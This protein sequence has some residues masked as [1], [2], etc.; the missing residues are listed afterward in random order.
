MVRGC[1]WPWNFRYRTTRA[2]QKRKFYG[3]WEPSLAFF[4][5]VR[6]RGPRF[7]LSSAALEWVAIA[8]LYGHADALT[9][10]DSI[11]Q[12]ALQESTQHGEL[13]AQHISLEHRG[14]GPARAS[15]NAIGGIVQKHARRV[16]H[17]RGRCR[18]ARCFHL[19]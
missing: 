1:D 9:H 3:N 16:R 19:L 5:G 10:R 13:R 7:Q 11:D 18:A 12:L 6:I 4:I 8:C 14:Q 17:D 2:D 15:L